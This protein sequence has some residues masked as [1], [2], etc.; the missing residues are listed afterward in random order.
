MGR[1]VNTIR[2]TLKTLKKKFLNLASGRNRLYWKR[3]SRKNKR[4]AQM[5]LDTTLKTIKRLKSGSKSKFTIF[6]RGEQRTLKNLEKKAT[7]LKS[8]ISARMAPTRKNLEKRLRLQKYFNRFYNEENIENTKTI[9]PI[10]ENI[11]LEIPVEEE[12]YERII[13]GKKYKLPYEDPKKADFEFIRY[14]YKL[15]KPNSP[16]NNVGINTMFKAFQKSFE[17]YKK[18]G[19]NLDNRDAVLEYLLQDVVGKSL[20]FIDQY[21]KSISG[22]ILPNETN[23]QEIASFGLNHGSINRFIYHL[24]QHPRKLE[25]ADEIMK[26]NPYIKGSGK[27]LQ[28]FQSNNTICCFSD[29][30]HFRRWKESQMPIEVKCSAT[31]YLHW[32]YLPVPGRFTEEAPHVYGLSS[33]F[34]LYGIGVLPLTLKAKDFPYSSF[35]QDAFNE[36]GVKSM[37]DNLFYVLEKEK[38]EFLLKSKQIYCTPRGF[39]DANK[40]EDLENPNFQYILA[41]KSSLKN[42]YKVSFTDPTNNSQIQ[43]ACYERE[44]YCMDPWT[45]YCFYKKNKDLWNQAFSLSRRDNERYSLLTEPEKLLF[46]CIYYFKFWDSIKSIEDL[47]KINYNFSAPSHSAIQVK[48]YFKV[49]QKRLLNYDPFLMEDQMTYQFLNSKL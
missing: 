2:R 1:R 28:T 16:I 35:I 33:T 37:D 9:Q 24:L 17:Q 20:E 3:L 36:Q 32:Q 41:K 29:D 6:T 13:Q 8:L 45:S 14:L 44:I 11:E 30:D 18:E 26:Y 40:L 34:T 31:I 39:W 47:E 38:P 19:R 4:H 27:P 5:R 43:K 22:K 46:H 10:L 15:Y 48:K 49:L 23:P 12:K 25:Y 42:D 21:I 7:S